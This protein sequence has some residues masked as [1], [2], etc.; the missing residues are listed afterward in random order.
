MPTEIVHAFGHVNVTG[1]NRTT[2][3][4]TR[5]SHLSKMGDCIIAVSA[6]K[7]LKNFSEAFKDRLRRENALVLVRVEAGG[8]TDVVRAFGNPGLTFTHR[9]DIVVRKSD[10][11]S[12]RTLAVHA[13]KSAC[14]LS[15]T[16][17]R[18]LQ[19]PNQ[20]VNIVFSVE[21]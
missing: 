8:E 3:E 12:D 17:V 19:N 18:K 1:L 6:D 20:E 4:V 2:F 15:R 14:S 9:T 21:G 7:S 11:V 13:D 5:E 10:F 16:L